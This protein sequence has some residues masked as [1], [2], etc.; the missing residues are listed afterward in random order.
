[1]TDGV[2]D[3]GSETAEDE[4]SADGADPAIGAAQQQITSNR[5]LH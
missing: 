5:I 4:A 3:L 2:E 1:M